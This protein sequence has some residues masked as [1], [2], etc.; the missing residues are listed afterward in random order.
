[1][2]KPGTKTVICRICGALL[3]LVALSVCGAFLDFIDFSLYMKYTEY[4]GY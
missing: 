4:V 3:L 2:V 1:M